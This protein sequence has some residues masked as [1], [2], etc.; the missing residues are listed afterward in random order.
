[1]L[2]ERLGRLLRASL[3]GLATPL[4]SRLHSQYLNSGEDLARICA[5]YWVGRMTLWFNIAQAVGPEHVFSAGNLVG[6]AEPAVFAMAYA[7][8]APDQQRRMT[9]LRALAPGGP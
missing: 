2:F 5:E 4:V 9:E 7:A 6:W 1:M 3:F 8:A